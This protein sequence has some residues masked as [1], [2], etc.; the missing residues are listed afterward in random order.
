MKATNYVCF[1]LEE[2]APRNVKK[3]KTIPSL[4]EINSP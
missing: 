2:K 4:W 1:K 3:N